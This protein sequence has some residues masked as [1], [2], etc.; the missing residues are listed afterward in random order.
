MR[1]ACRRPWC[2][3]VPYWPL[4][5]LALGVGS[6]S[7]RHPRPAPEPALDA[8]GDHVDDERDEEGPKNEVE[9]ANP[10]HDA[11]GDR[12]RNTLGASAGNFRS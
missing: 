3:H 2:C 12:V 6:T 7:L 4:L 9:G 11:V 1:C 5:P 8:D 10:Q